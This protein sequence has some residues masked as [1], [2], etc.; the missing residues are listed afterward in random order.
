M[1]ASHRVS[2]FSMTNSGNEL[3]SC[4]GEVSN[5]KHFRVDHN[6][7]VSTGGWAPIRCKGAT[8]GNHPQGIWDH[9][10][11]ED[12][13]LHTNGTLHQLDE[14]GGS[15]QHVIWAQN[16]PLGDSSNIVY[17][18][19]NHFIG[20]T[21]NINFTDGNYGG[22]A[23]IRF[24]RTQGTGYFEF[25]S[26]Q[27][28]NRGFQRW[29][30]YNNQLVDPDQFDDCYHGMASVRGGTGVLFDNAM[31]GAVSGC[32][33]DMILDNVRSAF[34]D[35]I[36]NPPG[37]C[38]GSST[39]DQNTPGEQGWR[40]R[41]QIGIGRDLSLWDDS[42]A[43]AWNQEVKPAY[44]WNNTRSPGV[45]AAVRALSA[46]LN[47]SHIQA[48]RDFY[49]QGTSFNGTS[50]VGRGT[51]ANRPSTCTTGVAYWATDEG[52]WNSLQAGPDG[53]LYKC[54]S[55]NTWSLY[56]MPYPYPHPWTVGGGTTATPGTPASMQLN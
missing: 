2:G 36:S 55:T 53:R 40:C 4:T 51:R 56:Y 25:H 29:E 11:I 24:N 7:L 12:V 3:V 22:R 26:P 54:T 45:L 32:N 41:D 43:R 20:S 23:V 35:P 33:N 48:N 19:A 28:Q 6:R 27:G 49:T 50:G 30:V 47:P 13:S 17:I 21:N 46:D 15:A 9:N 14:S 10:R 18:E 31:S 1:G 8:N 16:T 37:L 52:E 44:F 42:P 38:T 39:W 34:D 5:S